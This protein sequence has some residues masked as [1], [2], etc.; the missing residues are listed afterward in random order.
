MTSL[1][2]EGFPGIALSGLSVDYC[3]RGSSVQQIDLMKR[4]LALK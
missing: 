3:V 1:A 2:G 4:R